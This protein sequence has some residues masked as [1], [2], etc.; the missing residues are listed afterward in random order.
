M[1]EP[2]SMR[3]GEAIGHDSNVISPG[4]RRHGG[5][6]VDRRGA[7]QNPTD[8]RPVIQSAAHTPK[9]PVPV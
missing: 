8:T 7:P 1:G 6:E 3:C 9:R 5:I 4:N 2:E